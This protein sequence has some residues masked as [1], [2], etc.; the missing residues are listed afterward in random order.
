[1]HAK[2]KTENEDRECLENVLKENH[3]MPGH[4]IQELK[5]YVH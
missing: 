4:E 3:R 5:S 2:T 1:V